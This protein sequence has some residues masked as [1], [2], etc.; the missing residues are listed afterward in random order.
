MQQCRRI[1]QVEGTI[2][3]LFDELQ[4]SVDRP[5]RIV[6]LERSFRILPVNVLRP[7][8]IPV[9]NELPKPFFILSELSIHPITVFAV[10][11]DIVQPVFG[12]VI[13]FYARPNMILSDESGGVS[14]LSEDMTDV[15]VVV[16][17]RNIECGQP[18]LPGRTFFEVLRRV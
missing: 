17:K 6:A 4:S 10:L 5:L 7:C 12:A 2:L 16:F 8:E 14:I 3:V 15:H 11:G 1:V 18:L 13:L 9:H